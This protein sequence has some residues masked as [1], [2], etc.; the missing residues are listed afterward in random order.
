MPLIKRYSNRKLYNTE[1]KQYITLDQIAQM[2]RD[3][4]EVFVIDNSTGEDITALTLTQIIYEQEKKKSGS[5]P[6]SVLT[7]LIQAGGEG[8]TAFQRALTAS[9]YYFYQIDEE[10]KYRIQKL[11]KQGELTE[12]EGKTLLDKLLKLRREDFGEE[13][14]KQVLDNRQVPTRKELRELLDQLDELSQKIDQEL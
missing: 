5:L 12:L 9:R 11:I 2:I 8:L 6:H 3:E 4:E 13:Q 7:N 14:V 1:G 10:I